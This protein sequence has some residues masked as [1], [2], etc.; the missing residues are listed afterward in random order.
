MLF[1]AGGAIFFPYASKIA[2]D[3]YIQ[4]RRPDGLVVFVTLTGLLMFLASLANA[5]RVRIM[6]RL[7]QET[8][9]QIRLDLFAHLQ[10]LPVA[11]FDRMP[12]GKI[13]TR[14]TS[15]VDALA[16]LLSGA[17]IQMGGD[18]LTLA[19]FL[20]VML[21][22]DWRL[23]LVTLAGVPPLVFAFTFL[24]RRI[25][26]AEDEVRER[27]SGVNATLQENVS[28]IRVIQAFWANDRFTAR[29]EQ[30]NQDLLRAGLRAVTV[31]GFFWP[32]VDFS[33]VAGSGLILLCG[34]VW[35]SRG[36]LTIGT[37]AAFLGYNTQFFGPLHGLSQ[38]FRII[39]RALAGAVRIREIM[40]LETEEKPGLSPAPPLAGCVEFDDVTFAYE[41]EPVLQGVD[42]VAAP[43]ELVA[44]VGRTGAGKTS[45]INL[46]CRFYAPQSGRI[47]LDGLDINGLELDGY[48]RQIALVLQEPFLFSGT[49]R[50]NLRY[51][52]TDATDG[53]MEEALA[54]VGLPE[55]SLDMILHER[56]GNLSSGQ[57]QLL[58]LAR[59]ILADPRLII[60][61]EA[62]AHVDTITERKVQAAMARLLAGRTAF[63]IAHRL[64]TIRSAGQILVIDDGRI[65]ERGSHGDLIAAR[66]TYWRLC[67]EQNLFAR[68]EL[69]PEESSAIGD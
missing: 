28:G 48:R 50:E 35:V 12:V 25:N 29:F 57:R 21:L 23:A 63:V 24:H 44:L 62:T 38:A 40:G 26:Q 43:G 46:L 31:F 20:L 52:R 17:V 1:G 16:E 39:Q 58:S 59:A 18:I 5:W 60:L 6:A 41:A 4:A 27:A 14:L 51:G 67:R 9:R 3:R 66:G 47:L 65:I 68:G 19:G 22:I 45:L 37:L 13:M 64:S 36:W 55:M 33:W 34:G 56:G 11:Y 30:A 7:G 54:A 61:D 15:D 49:L 8:I 42:L 53:E 10:K 32:I 2:I 69:E